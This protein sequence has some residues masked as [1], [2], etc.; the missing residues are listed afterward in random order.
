MNNI[1]KLFWGIFLFPDNVLTFF[2]GIFVAVSVNIL[3]SQI[4]QSVF[5]IGWTFFL[6]AIL[7]FIIA[8]ILLVWSA[9]VRSLQ[10]EYNESTDIRVS[11]GA[12][13]C[14]YNIIN[15]KTNQTQTVRKKL[16]VFF[17]LFVV[18]FVLSIILLV[19]SDDIKSM[20]D[21]VIVLRK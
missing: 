21:C 12:L 17:L 10:L 7:L 9:T 19:F 14:W 16:I 3:T 2:S 18:L 13:E 6:A 20:V 5:S 1:K 11:I 15:R 8:G 4:P